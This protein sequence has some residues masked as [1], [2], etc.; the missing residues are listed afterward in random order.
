MGNSYEEGKQ[1]KT[2]QN[3]QKKVAMGIKIPME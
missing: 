3:E 1:N 2:K